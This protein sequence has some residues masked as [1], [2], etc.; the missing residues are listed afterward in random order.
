[1]VYYFHLTLSCG[2][3]VVSEVASENRGG[4]IYVTSLNWSSSHKYCLALKCSLTARVANDRAVNM[5]DV[6]C[7]KCVSEVLLK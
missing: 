2:Y 7:N 5:R 1:V 3:L 6:V 4:K